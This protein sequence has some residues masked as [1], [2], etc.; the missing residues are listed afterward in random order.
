MAAAS[1]QPIVVPEHYDPMFKVDVFLHAPLREYTGSSADLEVNIM[2][3]CLQLDTLLRQ[4]Y[5]PH[6]LHGNERGKVCCTF[7]DKANVVVRNLQHV[8]SSNHD[9][10]DLE[11]F[12]SESGLEWLFPRV[13]SYISNPNKFSMKLKTTPID[14]YL[15]QMS[16][17]HHVLALTRQIHYDVTHTGHKYLTHQLAAL[18][19]AISS[20]PSGGKA[21]SSER[22]NIEEN[23][24][25]L[26]HSIDD[27][28]DREDELRL[29][30][31][32]NWILNLTESIIQVISSM[33]RCMTEE[34][35]P[36]AQVLEQ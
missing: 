15:V 19:H 11:L 10:D 4:E 7:S 21:L 5:T 14:N 22:N 12:L 17:L 29:S 16:H 25:A 2:S 8:L 31:I 3:L 32:R 18:Y 36:V 6:K 30:E 35:L 23:F 13:A 1:Y 28:L 20:I 24:K 9:P 34:I 26:K 33:P 27:I